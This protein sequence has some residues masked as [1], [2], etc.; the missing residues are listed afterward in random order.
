MR[1][2]ARRVLLLALLALLLRLGW[3]AYAGWT[4]GGGFSYDDERLHWQLGRNLVTGGA[5]VSDDGRYAAR[6]PLYPLLL[7]PFAALGGAGVLLARV[8]QATIGAATVALLYSLAREGLGRRAALLAGLLL[9]LDPF[10]IFFANLLLTEVA[11][12]CVAV[13]LTLA[14]WRLLRNPRSAAALISVALL[15]GAAVFTRP[16]SLGWVGALWVVLAIFG[17]SRPRAMAQVFLCATALAVLLVNWGARNQRVIGEYAL[18]STNGG[19]TLYDAQ[20]PQADGSSNQA[21]L[22]EMPEL[23]GLNEPQ[24]DRRLRE[25]AVTQMRSDPARVARLAWVKFLRTWS[26]TPNEANHRSGATAVASAAFT[27]LVLLAAL[28]A[29]ARSA[30][31]RARRAAPAKDGRDARGAPPGARR[32]LFYALLLL[33]IVYFTVVHCVYVG[34]LRYRI[35]LMPFLEVLA[36]AAVVGGSQKWDGRIQKRSE[37]RA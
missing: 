2:D 36:A 26:L 19:V 13:G 8:A 28:T 14:V 25:L 29:L 24:R 3:I 18:L 12:T 16:S 30:L 23:E 21:F 22:R 34:S 11:F 20:G 15:G 35:P 7:A 5:L 37:P 9:A 27:G 17:P 4:S 6:M 31:R 32:G 33:P 10:S 1:G